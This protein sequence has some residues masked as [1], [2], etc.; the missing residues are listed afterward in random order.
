MEENHRQE[1]IELPQDFDIEE[2]PTAS[3]E[4]T[5]IVHAGTVEIW[6]ML[7]FAEKAKI[8]PYITS[9]IISVWAAGIIASALRFLITGNF[10]LIL[11]PALISAPLYIILKFYFRSG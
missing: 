9:I 3:N 8:R 2:V 11:P 7:E 1:E 4:A 5:E 6:R 10:L